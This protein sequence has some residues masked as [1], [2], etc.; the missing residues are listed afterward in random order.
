MAASSQPSADVLAAFVEG[1][2]LRVYAST[3]AGYWPVGAASV[4]VATSEDEARELLTAELVARKIEPVVFTLVELNT[5]ERAVSV[6]L[7]GNY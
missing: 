2:P 7:D 1:A 3:H 6:L 5:A 4:V